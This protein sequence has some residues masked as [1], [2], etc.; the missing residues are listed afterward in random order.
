MDSTTAV[1]PILLHRMMAFQSNF[2]RSFTSGQQLQV[3][4]DPR[5]QLSKFQPTS[6]LLS[7][8]GLHLDLSEQ[9]LP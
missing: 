7:P 8:S 5:L 6:P 4:T 9:W 3:Q 1:V 2:E